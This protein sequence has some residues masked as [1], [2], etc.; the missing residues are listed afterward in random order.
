M[1]ET[2]VK[3]WNS[4]IGKNDE[5]YHLGDVAVGVQPSDPLGE[6]LYSLNGKIYLINGNHERAAHRYP[7]RF[8]W[9]KDYFELKAHGQHIVMFHYAQRV[10]H[11]SHRGSWHLYGH[12]HG[13]LPEII[14][15]NAF[16][17]GMDCWNFTPL[18]FDQIHD[19]MLEKQRLYRTGE[20]KGQDV[21]VREA[22]HH[23]KD[24]Y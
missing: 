23:G 11:K 10:W 21:Q 2:I 5:V 22:G 8:E 9:I 6:L 16:D 18:S 1:N 19:R 17:V 24:T 15:V 20:G 12:S 3:N 4:V 13:D 7:Q 14:G